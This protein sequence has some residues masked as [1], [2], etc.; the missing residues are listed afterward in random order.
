MLK[1]GVQY[2]T[3]LLEFKKVTRVSSHQLGSQIAD[4]IYLL[5]IDYLFHNSVIFFIFCDLYIKNL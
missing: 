3:D 2:T 5:I 4:L 1:L